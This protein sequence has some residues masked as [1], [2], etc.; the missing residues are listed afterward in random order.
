MLFNSTFTFYVMTLSMTCDG[1]LV[2]RVLR[3]LKIYRQNVTDKLFQAQIWQ[4]KHLYA[5]SLQYLIHPSNVFDKVFSLSNL[6]TCFW[7]KHFTVETNIIGQ[8]YMQIHWEGNRS[9]NVLNRLINWFIVFNATFS[10]ISAISW[11]QALVVEEPGENHRP[12]AS[13]W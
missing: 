11:R 3:I 2:F 9:S 12:W 6:W 1:S 4:S 10:N 7:R 8:P 13:N 5:T